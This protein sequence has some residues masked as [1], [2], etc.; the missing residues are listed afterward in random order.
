[1]QQGKV[2]ID[3]SVRRSVF[4]TLFYELVQHVPLDV[5]DGATAEKLVYVRQAVDGQRA[6]LERLEG[7]SLL[8]LVHRDK[9]C[10]PVFIAYLAKFVRVGDSENRPAHASV[11]NYLRF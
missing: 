4:L 11:E 10:T 3:V 9:T 6:F 8:L 2:S 7:A 5:H 1:M